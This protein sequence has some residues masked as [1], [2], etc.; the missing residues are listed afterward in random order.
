VVC[1]IGKRA[2]RDISFEISA[3]MEIPEGQNNPLLVPLNEQ[4]Y[5]AQGL[6]FLAPGAEIS[7]FW[8]SMITLAPYLDERGFEGVT[9]TTRYKSLEGR[10]HT[11]EVT[12]NPLLVRSRVSTREESINE[13]AE[14]IAEAT[15]QL[16]LVL[17]QAMESS[18]G[19]LR[20]STNT[21]RKEREQQ[22][23]NSQ[24]SEQKGT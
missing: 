21:E 16:T 7:T 5:F 6:P 17:Q 22:V 12:I 19:E 14:K 23:L 10:A 24:E 20:V 15:Q 3:P 13:I 11:S 2:A 4:G 9:I 8:G 18:Y 1:N